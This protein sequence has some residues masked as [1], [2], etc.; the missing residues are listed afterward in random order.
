MTTIVRSYLRRTFAVRA[1]TKLIAERLAGFQCVRDAF[2][3][4]SFTAEADE[5]FAF[6][7]EDVLLGD[8]LRGRDR[9]AGQNVGKF[10]RDHAVELRGELAAHHAVNRELR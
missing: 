2:L 8:G 10:S 3:G 6:E 7:I 1:A 5:C 4:F 9:A